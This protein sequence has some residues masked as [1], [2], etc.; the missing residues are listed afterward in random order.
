MFAALASLDDESARERLAALVPELIRHNRLY[1]ETDAAEID[2]RTYDMLYRELELL[3]SRFPEHI[4]DDSPTRRVGGAPVSHLEPFAHR[5]PMLSLS[6]AFS[7]DELRDFDTR[8]KRFLGDDAP[9]DVAYVVEPK[10]DGLAAELVYEEGALVGAGTRGDGLVGEDVLHNVVTIRDI[11]R[12]LAGDTS[13]FPSRLSVR[14]EIFYPLAGFAAMNQRRVAEGSKAFENP[15]NAAAGTVRQLDPAVAAQRPLTFFA[16]SFGEAEGVEPAPTHWEQLERIAQWGLPANPLNRR[17]NGIEE[18]IRLIEELGGNRHDLAYEIDGAVVKVDDV[19]KQATLGA[20][21][22]SPRWAIA[23]KFPPPQ[24]TT[25][26]QHVG[27]QVGRTGAITPV[28]HL[29]PARVGGVTVSRATLHNQDQ[30]VLLDIRIGD[31]V[32]IERAGD[33]IPRVVRAVPDDGHDARPKPVFPEACPECA[34][35]LLKDPE[36]A[37]IRCPNQLSCPAQLRAAVRH[38]A[39]RRA[40]DIDG[41]GAKLVDQL[42]DRGMVKRVSDLFTLTRS[43]LTNLERMGGK[44]ADNLLQALDVSKERPLNRCLTALGI[45][46][47]GESTA[48]DLANHFRDIDALMAA[49]TEELVAVHGIGEVVAEHVVKYFADGRFRAEL[50]RLRQLGVQFPALPP[51]PE[52][53]DDAEDAAPLLTGKTFVITGTLPTLDRAE[54]KSRILA[55]GGKVTGSVSSKTDFLV[56]GEKAGSKLSK[57]QELGVAVIDEAGLLALLTPPTP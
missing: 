37:V 26:L 56:A 9:E 38:F 35:P 53:S 16:H 17:A 49:S 51:L 5:V 47:V 57:A 39:S 23:F 31:Q 4:R 7:D 2:D 40:M 50:A 45:P 24:V 48:R 32:V 10:L 11:P 28:A 18:V 1:H 54:A 19:D 55:V 8:V 27:F 12:T 42:V 13:G 25:T 30:L 29:E 43:Q 34:T 52:A 36:Q 6:N 46:E 14:G 20:V 15:R 44:S 21:T 22:R 41:L 3:E 33:V